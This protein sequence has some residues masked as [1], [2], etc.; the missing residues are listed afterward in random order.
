M[1]PADVDAAEV[2]QVASAL[3]LGRERTD[4][5]EVPD[6]ATGRGLP[7][8]RDLLRQRVAA[9]KGQAPPPEAAPL[10]RDGTALLNTLRV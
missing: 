6:T 5:D 10:G 7:S 4:P 9:A 2:W 8:S 3:G 1:T